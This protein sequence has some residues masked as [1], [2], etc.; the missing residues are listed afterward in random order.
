MDFPIVSLARVE[1]EAK[2][3]AEKGLS[4]NFACPYPFEDPAGQ[5]FRRVFNE[6]RAVVHARPA[7]GSQAAQE[8]R[9]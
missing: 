7:Q 3:A 5:A 1:R 8:A 4:M 2:E 9:A 6:H